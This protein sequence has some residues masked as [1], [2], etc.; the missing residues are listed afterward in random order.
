MQK[1][2][3]EIANSIFYFDQVNEQALEM[4]CKNLIALGRHSLPKT[5]IEKFAK[6]YRHMYDEEFP[7]GV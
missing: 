2:L 4:K 5:P 3:I 6:D 7:Q 1:L